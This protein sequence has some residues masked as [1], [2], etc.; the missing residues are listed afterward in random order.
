MQ[1]AVL[2]ARLQRDDH[3]NPALLR[4]PDGR[5]LA[6]YSKHSGPEMLMRRTKRPHDASEWEKERVLRLYAG[7]RKRKNITYPNPVMLSGEKNRIW[8]FWRGDDWKPNVSWSDDLGETW[9]PARTLVS[10]ARAR[11][12]AIAPT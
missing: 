9:A 1:R 8:M 2:H 4:L 11:A 12:S 3:V 5:A 10:R 6:F 7:E